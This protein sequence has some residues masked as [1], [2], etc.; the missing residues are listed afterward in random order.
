MC[1][2]MVKFLYRINITQVLFLAKTGNL[3]KF[4]FYPKLLTIEHLRESQLATSSHEIN[5]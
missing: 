4:I 5:N 3:I 2:V 1:Y